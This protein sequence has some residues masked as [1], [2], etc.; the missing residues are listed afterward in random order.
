MILVDCADPRKHCSCGPI[1]RS[2]GSGPR[3]SCCFPVDCLRSNSGDSRQIFVPIFH[4]ARNGLEDL[5]S[6]PP[7]QRFTLLRPVIKMEGETGMHHVNI[8]I[9]RSHIG[10]IK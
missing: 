4:W 8:L 1:D 6:R 3:I 9:K 2:G 5:A 10:D 7:D